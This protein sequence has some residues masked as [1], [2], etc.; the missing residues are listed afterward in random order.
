MHLK[1]FIALALIATASSRPFSPSHAIN[2]FY[3]N[4]RFK[5]AFLTCSIKAVSADYVAQRLSSAMQRDEETKRDAEASRLSPLKKARGGDLAAAEKK[6]FAVDWRRSA[7]F[8]VYGGFYQGM[9]IE[10]LYNNLLPILGTATDI[11]TVLK[12]VACDMGFVSPLITI[13]SE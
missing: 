4:H 8:F 1:L 13:P 12:K 6:K 11:K 3:K 9:G 5:G 2:A 10:F 7:A